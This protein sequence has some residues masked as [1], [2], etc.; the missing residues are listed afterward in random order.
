MFYWVPIFESPESSLDVFQVLITSPLLY[1]SG[2]TLCGS[3]GF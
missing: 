3:F 1:Y 2:S